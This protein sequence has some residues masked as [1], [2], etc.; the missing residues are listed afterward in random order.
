MAQIITVTFNPCIDK[1]TTIP[2]LAPE[3]KLRCSEPRFEPGGGGIN[4]ARAIKKL[5]GEATAIYP[6][7]GYSG[8]FLNELMHQEEVPVKVVPAQSHTR[9]NLIVMDTSTNQQYRFGMPGSILLESEWKECLRLVEEDNEVNYIVASGSL[10]PGVPVDVYARL[11]AIAK[12]KAARFIVDT[13]GEALMEAAKEGVYLLK[14]NLAELSSLV[15]KEEIDAEYI[16]DVAREVIAKGQCEIIITSM[17]PGGAML[18]TKDEIFQV[19]PPVVRRKST[20]GAG[21]SMVAGVVLSLSRGWEVSDALKYGVAAG[22]AATL[23]PGTELCRLED[24]QRLY[25]IISR[26]KKTV[27]L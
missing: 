2:A 22:T 27:S 18:V 14:P 8:N 15:G 11:A 7:G 21:D 6:A 24:V 4:V 5:G 20:V 25:N 10:T 9:E 23:N 3:K 13:S 19:T 12:K 17:G 26:D 1:S 16:D